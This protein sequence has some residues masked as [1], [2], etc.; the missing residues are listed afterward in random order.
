MGATFLPS[1]HY[2]LFPDQDIEQFVAALKGA[3]PAPLDADTVV[4]QAK[5]A[6]GPLTKAIQIGGGYGVMKSFH[7]S[8]AHERATISGTEHDYIA[9][10]EK[11]QKP[12]PISIVLY[13]NDAGQKA[14]RIAQLNP[15]GLARNPVLAVLFF[16]V[17]LFLV[18]KRESPAQG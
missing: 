1:L 13:T 11:T 9:W 12:M 6:L 17:S 15:V 4:E 16:L 8:G 3:G 14:Y 10:F 2:L 18:R 7:L 5:A